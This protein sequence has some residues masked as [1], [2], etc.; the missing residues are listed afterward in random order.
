MDAD[1][2]LTKM[3]E[4]SMFASKIGNLVMAEPLNMPDCAFAFGVAMNGIL[5]ASKQRGL[6]TP[7]KAELD[8]AREFMKGLA[9]TTAIMVR[10]EG[11]K[12]S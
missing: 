9:A 11:K 7:E 2:K 8:L 3:A 6:T 12:E 1:E 10:Y 5:E 4:I